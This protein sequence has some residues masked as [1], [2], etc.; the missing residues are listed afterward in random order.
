MAW[1]DA[2]LGAPPTTSPQAS[3]CVLSRRQ[4]PVSSLAPLSLDT[5]TVG[6]VSS[7]VVYPV[8]LAILFLFR[9]SRSKVGAWGS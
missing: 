4:G 2:C 3:P 1:L 5:V 9:M 8:Y 6:L 7:L